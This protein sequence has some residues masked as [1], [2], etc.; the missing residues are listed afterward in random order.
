MHNHDAV[1][2]SVVISVGGTALVLVWLLFV[3]ARNA[4]RSKNKN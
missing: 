1:F 3:V 2:W 4:R